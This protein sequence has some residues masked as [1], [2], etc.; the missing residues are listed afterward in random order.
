MSRPKYYSIN[1]IAQPVQKFIQ[2]EKAGGIVLGISVILALTIANTPWS[3]SYHH[4]LEYRLGFLFQGKTYLEYDVHHWINDGLMAIFFFVVGLELKREMTTGALSQPR[5][6]LLPIAAA[7]GGML[8][9]AIIYSSLNPAG[10]AAKGWG[11]PMATDIAFAL[12]VLSLL[13]KKIPLALKV[14][15]T[16]LA[17]VDDLGA[18]LVIALFYTTDISITHLLLG[19]LFLLIMYMGNKAGIRSIVFYAILGIGGAWLCFL[20]SGVHAT[21]AAVLAAFTI[22]VD[23]KLSRDNYI[24]KMQHYLEQLKKDA[25]AHQTATLTSEQ[26]HLMDAAKKDT[27]H[28]IPPLQKLEHAMQPYV[29][30]LIIPI[31]ALANAGVSVLDIDPEQIFGNNIAW[32]VA[33]G[34]LIGKVIGVVGFTLLLVKL[35]IADL[36]NGMHTGNLLGMG[37]L[38]AIGFTMSLFI[39]SLA[40]NHEAFQTQAKLGIFAASITGGVLGYMILKRS[41]KHNK[42]TVVLSQK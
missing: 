31:F 28:A 30:F 29:S 33:G 42:E 41:G 37:F 20:L 1:R 4:V 23:V 32:G 25:N 13:G 39:T 18:V 14:F 24:R 34:L 11:I 17:I 38:A 19:L 3:A 16:A 15:L 6:A 36:P 21:V 22:P 10:E 27:D 12:G 9:P 8:V 35:K 5:N 2:H 26:L 40:F 7:V